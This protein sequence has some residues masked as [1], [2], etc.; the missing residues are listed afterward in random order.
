[1]HHLYFPVTLTTGEQR[2][3]AAGQTCPAKLK[4][5]VKEEEEIPLSILAFPETFSLLPLIFL[6]EMMGISKYKASFWFNF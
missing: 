6:L 1:M 5:F 2:D 4:S 3:V